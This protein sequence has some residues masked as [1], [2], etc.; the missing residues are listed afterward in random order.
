MAPATSGMSGVQLSTT[1][2]QPYC[3]IS[4]CECVVLPQPC[5]AEKTTGY[6]F[7]NS[8]SL[9]QPLSQ[10]NAKYSICLAKNK[11]LIFR[12]LLVGREDHSRLPF[13]TKARR[14]CSHSSRQPAPHHRASSGTNSPHQWH[15]PFGIGPAGWRCWSNAGCSRSMWSWALSA[16]S[17]VKP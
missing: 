13:L 16:S 2:V 17:I 10:R 1:D 5:G 8:P 14:A 15:S 9:C 12:H 4:A 7:I 3:F 11:R 6:R